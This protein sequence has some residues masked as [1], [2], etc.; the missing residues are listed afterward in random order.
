VA[1]YTAKFERIIGPDRIRKASRGSGVIVG[2]STGC[3]P[4]VSLGPVV[5]ARSSIYLILR[6]FV[7]RPEKTMTPDIG[8]M[9]LNFELPDSTGVVRGL[10]ALTASQPRV[11]IFYRGHW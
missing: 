7:T 8:E 9:T 5:C 4:A 10:D 1:A 6:S 3:A 11:L 2:G